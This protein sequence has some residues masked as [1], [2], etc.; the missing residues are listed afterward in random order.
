MSSQEV[1]LRKKL[2]KKSRT[3]EKK[4]RHFQQYLRKVS[5][6]PWN[7]SNIQCVLQ[8]SESFFTENLSKPESEKQINFFPENF[9]IFGKSHC[10]EKPIVQA[11]CLIPAENQEAL[12]LETLLKK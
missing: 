10:A 4:G 2:S 12:R 6:V 11:K 8:D 9:K 1:T 3:G 7:Q 5:S